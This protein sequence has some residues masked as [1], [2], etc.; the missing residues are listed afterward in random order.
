[1]R[2]LTFGQYIA[3]MRE[4]RGLSIREVA[5][6]CEK[7]F[8]DYISVGTI[9]QV[10]KAGTT[11]PSVRTAEQLAFALGLDKAEVVALAMAEA[12]IAD[13]AK[14]RYEDYP[15]YADKIKSAFKQLGE[16]HGPQVPDEEEKC[17]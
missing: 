17:A 16:E 11:N 15:E 1:M 8:K 12:G 9:G 7:H 14:R 10:E 13:Y 2:R 6:I 3:E 4:L 5:A